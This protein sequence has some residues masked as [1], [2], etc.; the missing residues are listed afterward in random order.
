MAKKLTALFFVLAGLFGAA[1]GVGAATTSDSLDSYG[2][3]ELVQ[4]ITGAEYQSP[5]VAS[6]SGTE[7]INPMSGALN[8]KVTD[9]VL[10]GKN[11]L[12]LVISRTYNS[13]IMEYNYYLERGLSEERVSYKYVYQYTYGNN[14]TCYLAFNS[15]QEMIES[16]AQVSF[17]GGA[18]TEC[19]PVT[20]M[21][22]INSQYVGCTYNYRDVNLASGSVVYTRVQSE[23]AVVPIKKT[24]ISKFCKISQLEGAL[25]N[26]VTLG[27][28]WTLDLPRLDMSDQYFEYDQDYTEDGDL[29]AC[30]RDY[31]GTFYDEFGQQFKCKETIFWDTDNYGDFV[32]THQTLSMLNDEDILEKEK[33]S[34]E[35]FEK[36]ADVITP[37]PT[38]FTLTDKYNHTVS[39]SR[40]ITYVDTNVKYYF[41][42]VGLLVAKEDKFGNCILYYYTGDGRLDYII[43]S[44]NRT[45]DFVW[46]T[47][48]QLSKITYGNREIQY[49]WTEVND[50][51]IDPNENL[52]A[53]N[54]YQLTVTN[55]AGEVTK[56]YSDF[57]QPVY[58]AD[59]VG[60]ISSFDNAYLLQ[61]IEYPTG[62]RTEYTYQKRPIRLIYDPDQSSSYYGNGHKYSII[63]RKDIE[64][65]QELNR[66]VY[67]YNLSQETLFAPDDEFTSV[68]TKKCKA[69]GGRYTQ[70]YNYTYT[71]TYKNKKL[72]K[73]VEKMGD[74]Y[75]QS[76]Y[77]YSTGKYG[78]LLS[79]TNQEYVGQETDGLSMTSTY[80]Y[81][82]VGSLLTS[83]DGQS[84]INNRYR[85]KVHL[86][87]GT[88]FPKYVFR[89]A[90]SNGE[91]RETVTISH[92]DDRPEDYPNQNLDGIACW[93]EQVFDDTLN[94]D[95]SIVGGRGTLQYNRYYTYNNDGEITEIKTREV[96]SS[97]TEIGTA[98]VVSYT[99]AQESG[100]G[101]DVTKNR[102]V[103]ESRAADQVVQP[104]GTVA[105]SQTLTK[106]MTYDFYGNLIREEGDGIDTVCYT[107]D[108]K[109]RLLTKK[110]MEGSETYSTVS[111]QYTVGNDTKTLITDENN[112]QTLVKYDGLG[113]Y[114]STTID[115]NGI[116]L[117][118]ES[119]T[120]DDLG[121]VNCKTVSKG[122]G[123]GE[124]YQIFTHYWS[125]GKLWREEFCDSAS[126]KYRT[127]E[128]TYSESWPD[129]DVYD[130]GC[131]RIE[132]VQKDG[133]TERTSYA[134][135]DVYGNTKKQIDTGGGVTTYDF[136]SKG[137]LTSMKNPN[138]NAAQAATPTESY[139]YDYRG[140]IL[141]VTNAL[142]NT[143][144][145]VYDFLG[146]QVVAYDFNNN[147]TTTTYNLYGQQASVSTRLDEYIEDSPGSSSNPDDFYRYDSLTQYYYDSNGNLALEKVK[148]SE[149]GAETDTYRQVSYTYDEHLRLDTV[150]LT[151]ENNTSTY[152]KYFYDLKGNPVKVV[153]GL[154]SVE[155]ITENNIPSTAAVTEYEYHPY[156]NSVTKII[157]PD[158]TTQYYEYN[159]WNQVEEQGYLDEDGEKYGTVEMS[160]NTIG[161][162]LSQT[163]EEDNAGASYTYNKFGDVLTLTDETGLR[164]FTY[165]NAG[166][167][168]GETGTSYSKTYSYDANGNRTGFTLT[169]GTQTL[170]QQEYVY[171]RLNR[172]T[173]I[174]DENGN[175]LASYSYDA[176]GNLLSENKGETVKTNYTYNMGGQMTQKTN[177]KVSDNSVISSYN[178][179]YYLDGNIK[180]ENNRTFTYDNQGRLK[181]EQDGTDTVSYTYDKFGNRAAMNHN[182]Q[183]TS[184]TYD[185]NNR[186]TSE[187]NNETME[188]TSYA[189]D[190]RGN[191]YSK[192][193]TRDYFPDSTSSPI[194][195]FG[196]LKNNT[197][198]T[199]E[200]YSY[201]GLNR[202]NEVRKGG[203]T[204]SYVY[205][206]EGIRTSKT[207]N[208]TTTD[209][210]LDGSDVVAETKNGSTT[211]Y[212]RGASGIISS[213]I[214]GTNN[215]TKYYLSDGHGNVTD[216][217]DSSGAV[218]KSYTY[219]AFGVEQNPS[220]SDTNPFRYRGEYYD[221][222]IEQ[223]YL[224]ARY[225]DPSLGRFTQQDPAMADGN[226]WYVY[227]GNNPVINVDPSGE[228]YVIAWSYSLSDL[229][230]Y[231]DSNGNVNWDKFTAENSFA[232]AAYTRK[233][234]LI[235][236]GIPESEI[237]IQRIDNE[238]DM[239]ATW[240][241]WAGY[242]VVEAMDIYSHGD[243][244][245]VIVAGGGGE[246]LE[247]TTKLNWGSV[248]RARM[249]DGKS[250]A[251]AHQPY[252]VFHGCNT[253]NGN[254]AQNF[255]NSQGVETYAQTGY[256]SFSRNSKVHIPIEDKA[257]S[258]DVY[259]FHFEY[260]NLYNEDGAGEVFYPQ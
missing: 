42:S 87:D 255:A 179:T 188:I 91:N 53:D 75:K 219:D 166:R 114:K 135:V 142:G 116:N 165:D 31:Y 159:Y 224:R 11:G 189:Y 201:N 152:T 105:S 148:T 149:P 134:F 242:D 143:A 41:N 235:N 194:D 2:S 106:T 71:Y 172:L 246:F 72:T 115:P 58:T 8:L 212:I 132:I 174:K 70:D 260:F 236:S 153:T 251:M 131:Q 25:V 252:V 170:Q 111:Y 171:D 168:V 36:I 243:E 100:Y 107:Y 181:Q 138:D 6:E 216:L 198:S 19:D 113:R 81:D 94:D 85:R 54:S 78:R 124:Q 118:T 226:N 48:N 156:L 123:T 60:T 112:K 98:D 186:L 45:V 24:S 126:N 161:E 245:G 21:G 34:Y 136:D 227:C 250:T 173:Q 237:D 130:T 13:Q 22:E 193:T 32:N 259:L 205:N 10:P 183:V 80:T 256:A 55:E 84:N 50:D 63:E 1:Y 30:Y 162:L 190:D 117:M 23:G 89:H 229:N 197:N 169:Q 83:T 14:R 257:T 109:N 241:M 239:R 29:Y 27:Q 202:L 122:T 228:M 218:V 220:D 204:V 191:L 157:L 213:A 97:E 200:L 155:N 223:I 215:T 15:E 28:N 133:E 147:P 20:V 26:A 120:Y 232:R 61:K 203:T 121:R 231:K 127:T 208:G 119:V 154:S 184:Y 248:W 145:T 195:F 16:G 150:K 253:A 137:V 125:S 258:G 178:Y 59:S 99:Y 196:L 3:V 254:F 103:T 49:S 40:C 96:N 7:D 144:K 104:D 44:Y 238:S 37:I 199:V 67:S 209:F 88:S 64:G 17:T 102:T 217:T 167:M 56:Y 146:R 158:G 35:G 187:V 62:G 249:I 176:N 207:V 221:S 12:D 210:L 225:Y 182:G 151:E 222:E 175:V 93:K 86:S 206:A 52:Q 74:Y 247:N 18:L 77:S 160:Y 180:S 192:R 177:R 141:N 66:V 140:E 33:N 164:T 68:A 39:Y 233:Q 129:S 69:D 46:N 163:A 43:D 211:N 108:S 128:Y 79:E 82:D 230:D 240:E 234:E 38:S 214:Q 110:V 9:L 4:S 90:V 73:V 47:N 57:V 244:N 139:T 65:G 76:E 95:G 185:L 5:Y 51:E 92:Y 101:T